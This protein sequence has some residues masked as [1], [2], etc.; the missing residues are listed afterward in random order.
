MRIVIIG[1]SKTVYFITRQLVERG[2]HVTIINRDLARSRE[3][4][5]ATKATVVFGEGTDVNR[6]E[7]AGARRAD[8]VLAL[9]S[10]DQ[11]NLIACQVAQKL[12][13]VPRT[14]AL[15]NDPEN[16]EVF[17]RLGVGIAFSAT[18][19]IASLIEQQASFEDITALMP[20]ADGRINITDVRLDA[21][22][23]AVGKSL[24][25]L[26]L[27]GGTLIAAILR[28]DEVL[29]PRGQTRLMVDD[30]L[31]LISQP[32]NQEDDLRTICGIEPR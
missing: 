1:G 6:L 3:L 31:I 4:S 10:H 27:S 11:D 9:T 15:V 5:Q 14:L 17:T 26:E 13:G 16:E 25:E 32:E 22:S 20:V 7:E 19:V 21:N 2:N 29:V 30:H 18:R 12:F 8:V 28:D 24:I 23:P